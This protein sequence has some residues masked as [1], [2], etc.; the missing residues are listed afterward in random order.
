MSQLPDDIL[1]RKTEAEKMANAQTTLDAH[2]QKVPP[3]EHIIPYS[4]E[5]FKSA[6]IEWLI[7]TD[8][9]N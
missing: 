3:K 5:L 9:V 7:A 8:Q 1:R 2:V 4:D 6:A